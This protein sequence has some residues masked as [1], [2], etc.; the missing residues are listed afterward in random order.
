MD[1]RLVIYFCLL[2]FILRSLYIIFFNPDIVWPDEKRFWQEATSLIDNFSLEAKG[3]FAHDMPLTGVYV[4]LVSFVSGSSVLIV[5]ISLAIVSSATIYYLSDLAHQIYPS[6]YTAPITAAITAFYPYFIYFSSLILS[7]TI[8][9]LFIVL[10]FLQLL[11]IGDPFCRKAG[12]TAGLLH[13]TR[14]T[15]IYFFPVV[16]VWQYITKRC[17]TREI[18]IFI[19]FFV[20]IILPWGVRNLVTTN[21]FSLL[22]SGSGQVL[23]EGN[24]PWNNTGGVSGS[25]SDSEEYL[26]ELPSGLDEFEQ[27][28]W[29][30]VKAV[31][32]ISS[33]LDRFITLSMKRFFRFWNIWPNSSDF[34]EM[35]YKVITLFGFLPVLLL[36]ILSIWIFRKDYKRL[37]I[38]CFFIA[39]YTLLHMVTIGSIRYRLPVEILLVALSSSVLAY[40]VNSRL[41]KNKR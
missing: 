13:L 24:N 25:F 32:F 4:A 36:S 34:H 38:I 19:L 5:K 30:K 11:K 12:I 35:K 17:G 14:P 23:W 21:H 29:K 8:F 20:L 6:K 39:Y 27:D 26:A 33:N 41:Q 31:E 15:L 9:L 16:L 40:I 10:F 1:K 18:M 2:G 7:E 22:T 28:K 3:K 37:S